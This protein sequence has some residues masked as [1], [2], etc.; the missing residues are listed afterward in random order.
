LGVWLV[1]ISDMSGSRFF[2]YRL[3]KGTGVWLSKNDPKRRFL[4]P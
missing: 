4:G 1:M 3:A 2:G